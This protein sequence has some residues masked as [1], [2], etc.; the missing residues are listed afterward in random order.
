MPDNLSYY[1]TQSEEEA[2]S[3]LLSAL[4][5]DEGLASRS[6]DYAVDLIKRIRKTRRKPGSL[7][8]F[9]QQYG[10][11]TA[12]GLALMSMAEA[13]L[14]IPDPATA[15]ALIRDKVAGTNWL[16]NASAE[17]KDWMTKIA[18]LGLKL[19]SGTMNSLFSKLGE[20]VIREAMGRAMKILGKQFV[21]GET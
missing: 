16:K 7:E 8:S 13:L 12:E 3:D 21:V 19:T 6:H 2:V 15:S 11:N 1:L 10:L 9:F 5:W 17:D 4:Q 14:R 18:G 20:P